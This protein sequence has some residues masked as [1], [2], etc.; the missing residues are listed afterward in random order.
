M[1]TTYIE[2]PLG[3]G[4]TSRLVLHTQEL[5]Q[6]APTESILVLCANHARQ[7]DFMGRLRE[8][9]PSPTASSPVYTYQGWVRNTLF[10]FWPLVEST[11]IERGWEG[12]SV[13]TPELS[14]MEETEWL[15]HRLVEQRI[16]MMPEA[17]HE[18]QGTRQALVKQLVRRI[19]LR[20]ENRL[21]R[22]EMTHRS[23]LISEICLHD[24]AWVE[25]A[26]DKACY[27][28]RMLDTNKQL[29]VFHAWIDSNEI[30]QTWMRQRVQHLVMDDVDETIPAA[31]FFAQFLMS[32]TQ[33]LMMA[34]D[35][36]GGS[37]RGYLNAYP[38]DW[39]GLKALRPGETVVL[40]RDD[41]TYQNAQHLLA[42]WKQP[43]IS[44]TPLQ[45]PQCQKR[46]IAMTRVEM[47]NTVI[48]DV[49]A[50]LTEGVP[51]GD[52]ALV[53]PKIDLVGRYH[54]HSA[55]KQLGVPVQ[56][57]SGIERPL[58]NPIAHGWLAL[59][60]WARQD[61]WQTPIGPLDWLVLGKTM[62][63]VPDDK[64]SEWQQAFPVLGSRINDIAASDDEHWKA[65]VASLPENVQPIIDTLH[66]WQVATQDFDTES[67]MLDAFQN[68]IAPRGSVHNDPTQGIQFSAILQLLESYR[69]QKLLF[70]RWQA[71]QNSPARHS[72]ESRNL[73]DHS[74]AIT[75]QLTFQSIAPF[76][77]SWLSQVKAGVVADSPAIPTPIDTEAILIGSPQKL[78][79]NEVRRRRFAWLDLSSREW[80]R[81]DNAPLYHAWVHSAVWDGT[82]VE[83]EEDF[84]AAVVRARAAHI[85]RTLM[86]LA[87]EQVVGYTS[88][89]DDWG[90]TQ[91]GLLD[92]ILSVSLPSGAT[93]T[94]LGNIERATL[95]DDQAPV[96]D[97]DG[98]T[99]A[100]TAVP[101]AGK[102]FVTVELILEQILR[103]TLPEQILVLTYMDS[104]AK[105]LLS[106]LKKKL[107][108]G[109]SLP[110]VSTIHSL[111]LRILT[112]TDHA[113]QLGFLP[114]DV[115]ILD[116]FAQAE[117][118]GAI[119]AET[120][121]ESARSGSWLGTLGRGIGQAKSWRLQP[122]ALAT[123][124]RQ[125][126]HWFRL[127]EF[128][129]G[130]IAYQNHLRQHAMLDFNDLILGAIQL[131]EA[132]PDIRSAYQQ[133]FALIIEDEAQDSSAILQDFLR[134]LSREPANLVRV[135][136]TNQSITTTFSTAEPK[137]FR[138]FIHSAQR[139]VTMAQSSRCAPDIMALANAWL[140]ASQRIPNLEE[141]FV[142]APMQPV[143][144]MN[145]ELMVP[146]SCTLHET[147]EAEIQT[148]IRQVVTFREVHS[149]TGSQASE[150]SSDAP[151]I[152]ILVR[153]N[154][155]VQVIASR[156]QQLGVPTLA[157]SDGLQHSSIFRM[158]LA[159][160]QLMA[161]PGELE[162]QATLYHLWVDAGVL[163]PSDNRQSVMQSVPLLGNTRPT[164]AIGQ[165]RDLWQRY[166]DLLDFQRDILNPNLPQLIIRVAQRWLV[167]PNDCSQG[168][169]CALYA[170]QLIQQR[171]PLDSITPLMWVIQGFEGFIQG[172]RG[173]RGFV[174]SNPDA[175]RKFVQV[176]SLHKS[177]G[178]EF[179]VVFMPCLTQEHFPDSLDMIR[180][181]DDDRLILELGE[182][183]QRLHGN[184]TK[185]QDKNAAMDA[186]KRTK[187]QEEARLI[188][189][190]L[191]RA[192]KA[193]LLSAH[194]QTQTRY[195]KSKDVQP[196]LIHRFVTEY[197]AKQNAMEFH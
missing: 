19:R 158:L 111:A 56:V 184:H 147:Q 115:T 155:M 139:V 157:M 78:I 136:D 170:E 164:E 77:Q 45:A 70:E 180:C 156:L 168:Y 84:N 87:T 24:T 74:Q 91:N 14:G 137:V 152:A 15:L 129:P 176:M 60:Q 125:R 65:V 58:E 21:S 71:L 63:Q 192:K 54:L 159:A 113:L 119:A 162:H 118:L 166:Y 79:D 61:Q 100:I 42:A 76:E 171:P 98:G 124:S 44:P 90:V 3:A 173:R 73:S 132:Y 123:I 23:A 59:L 185:P 127:K 195:G 68:W 167:T 169:L 143:E 186:L 103:G 109:S 80:A 178:Q 40:E 38:Y 62:M 148:L 101:G 182:A 104:A 140:T 94:E 20:S 105:T 12:E 95:R 144:G 25:Q 5:L 175:L 174:E 172:R 150:L 50:W 49:L 64:V 47:L 85:T 151:S 39:Q 188:Y 75:E 4:K 16:A 18:F 114:D 36:D 153:T 33:T 53:L 133:R 27:A 48:D 110:V 135:G 146:L 96:L 35:I 142:S 179:D 160:L 106:R 196:S 190:G 121:P 102:T 67:L 189:V 26:F 183:R 30:V 130:Y 6:T 193:L 83:L 81:T 82:S 17:F 10:N 69:E 8:L 57:L 9:H 117:A 29:D 154:A 187:L 55:L 93:V 197:L 112:D 34:A 134:L 108:T 99:M 41:V 138:E 66:R 86:L 51:P 88:E 107:P 177:K 7:Q 72:D 194:L 128:L 116:E 37:R 1:I 89:L 120:I 122:E 145:P 126:P 141:A 43:D 28:L 149:D 11:L 161:K 163:T 52:I 46:P 131:L 2:G 181:K 32:S 97:Y 191:T 31:Q 165:D 22:R 92:T 13:I